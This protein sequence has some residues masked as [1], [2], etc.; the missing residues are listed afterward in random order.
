MLKSVATIVGKAAAEMDQA[1]TIAVVDNLSKE[2]LKVQH[3]L[4]GFLERIERIE[5]RFVPQQ[6]QQQLYPGSG[7]KRNRA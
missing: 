2:V 3:V 5:S 7:R 1:G 6:P 4:A